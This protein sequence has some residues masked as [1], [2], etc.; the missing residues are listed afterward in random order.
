MPPIGVGSTGCPG[1]P[2]LRTVQADLPHTA[3]RSVVLPARGLHKLVMGSGKGEEPMAV[4]ESIL[5]S[6]VSSTTGHTPASC[7][8]EQDTPKAHA[9]PAVDEVEGA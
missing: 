4:K 3:L 6:L 8:F 1:A 5:P 7:S 9:Q 2:S